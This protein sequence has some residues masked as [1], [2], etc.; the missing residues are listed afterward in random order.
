[1]SHT[2]RQIQSDTRYKNSHVTEVLSVD[3]TPMSVGIWGLEFNEQR[4]I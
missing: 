2:V 4:G 1:M 3:N